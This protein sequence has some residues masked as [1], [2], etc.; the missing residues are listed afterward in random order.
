M[1][2]KSTM[3][4]HEYDAVINLN[5]AGNICIKT[6]TKS[7]SKNKDQRTLRGYFMVAELEYGLYVK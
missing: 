6:H 7:P 5:E 3:Y 4:V 1:Y 2:G